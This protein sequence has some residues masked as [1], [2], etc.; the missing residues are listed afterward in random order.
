M[1]DDLIARAQ[2]TIDAPRADVWHALVTP[3]E[4]AKYMFGAEVVSDFTEGSRIV[5][6]G[7]WKGKPFEDRGTVRRVVPGRLLEYTH[8]SPLSGLPDEPSSYHTV[9]IEL[10]GDGP[11]TR[12]VLTQDNNPTEQARAH[13]EGNWAAMLQGLKRVVEGG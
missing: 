5:W 7:E 3:A 12:V 4:I 6:R 1:P 2:T 9:T 13:S 11:A 10:A 8:Y